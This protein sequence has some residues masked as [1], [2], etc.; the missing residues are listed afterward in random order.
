MNGL[1]KPLYIQGREP[2]QVCLDGPAL[3]VSKQHSDDRRF[4]LGRISRVVVSGDV[5]WSSAALVACGDAG[6]VVC[7]LRADGLPCGH[8][9]GK[10]ST[11][12]TFAEDWRHFLDRPDGDELLR[13]W[14][15][16]VRKRAI[17]FCALR[18]GIRCWN[19]REL[20]GVAGRCAT[21]DPS[22]RAAKR[23]VYGLAYARSLEELAK[24]G[25]CDANA[26]LQRVTSDLVTVI[27]WGLHPDL[28]DWWRRRTTASAS[29][30]ADFFERN[31]AT[32]EFHLRC[33]LMDLARFLKEK[34]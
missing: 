11:R 8:R 17:R 5:G 21:N 32:V 15:I 12:S 28:C 6:I 2:L 18:L 23:S 33:A 27:Q 16:R 19:V 26:L 1:A 34:M 22:F 4:P 9:I 13:Q 24:L 10:P 14:R 31:H 3:R 30:L 29:D 25:L 20:A 7:F